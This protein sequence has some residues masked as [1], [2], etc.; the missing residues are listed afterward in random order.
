MVFRIP[1]DGFDDQVQFIGAVDFARDAVVRARL[2]GMGFGEVL[3]P[4]TV[5]QEFRILRRILNVAVKKKCLAVNPCRAVEFP[6]LMRTVTK[7]PYY[8]SASEQGED[9]VCCAQLPAKCECNSGRDRA[10]SLQRVDANEEI[11]G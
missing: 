3:K 4:A 7:K 5:H 1:L 11:A 6:V 9:R 8:L 2:H 10:S